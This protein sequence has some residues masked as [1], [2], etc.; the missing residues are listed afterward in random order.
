MATYVAVIRKTPRTDYWVSIPDLPGCASNGKTIA[1]AKENFREA[2]AL[3]LE[4]MH[5]N[6]HAPAAPRTPEQFS[7]ED[8]EGLVESYLV[9]I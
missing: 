2:L 8:L 5:A 4:S 3:H 9:T 6:G 1:A 7:V